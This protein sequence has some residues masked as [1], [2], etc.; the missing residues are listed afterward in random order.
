MA[1]STATHDTAGAKHNVTHNLENSMN[2][3]IVFTD[4]SANDVATLH[5]KI[6]ALQAENDRL[7]KEKATRRGPSL[8]FKATDKGG[9]SVYG[10][11]RFPVT[12]RPSQWARLQ[13]ALPAIVA[14]A[15]ENAAYFAA[16]DAKYRETHNG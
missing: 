11:Q 6:A 8:T 9:I 12:L 13:E 14:Y 15:K 4:L 10:L 5:A 2:N 7:A 1:H 16:C 3:G